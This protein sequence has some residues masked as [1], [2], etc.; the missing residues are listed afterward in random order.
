MAAPMVEAVKTVRRGAGRLVAELHATW[1]VLAD[2]TTK[3]AEACA[4]FQAPRNR[5]GTLA[6]S[7][8]NSPRKRASS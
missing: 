6:R 5:L 7:A 4:L 8:S 1:D 3:L 2:L